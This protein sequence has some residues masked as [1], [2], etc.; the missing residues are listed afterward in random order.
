MWRIRQP[1][2][3]SSKELATCQAPQLW[4]T[5]S[6]GLNSLHDSS[7]VTWPPKA[8]PDQAESSHQGLIAALMLRTRTHLRTPYPPLPPHSKAAHL[9]SLGDHDRAVLPGRKP[10]SP[11]AGLQPAKALHL[12]RKLPG[13]CPAQPAAAPG[14]HLPLQAH[15][16]G[17]A[18]PRC[19]CCGF[20]PLHHPCAAQRQSG[21]V[22]GQRV[23]MDCRPVRLY[24]RGPHHTI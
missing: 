3:C 23:A 2:D 21:H 17:G 8:L 1:T 16:Q 20:Q 15:S 13:P 4:G 18:A 22:R 24:V 10:H 6:V 12:P 7:L 11:P 9:A 14:E 5:S 19:H